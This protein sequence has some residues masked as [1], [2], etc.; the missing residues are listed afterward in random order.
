MMENTRKTEIFENASI[1]KAVLTLC[2]PTVIS[3]L[4]M[5][6][7][8]LADTWFVGL[9]ND[10][11]QN[12]AVTFAAP[13]LLAFNA[14]NNLFGVGTSSMMGRALG[15]KDINTV[16]R[17]SAFGFWAA[18]VCGILFSIIVFIFNDGL[19]ALLGAQGDN[20]ESTRGY[21]YWT[22][23]WGAAPSILNV[24]LAYLVRTEGAVM[25]ASIGTMGGCLLNII[26][27]PIFVLPQ[28]LDMGAAGAGLATFISNV[29]A[30]LYFFVL[31]FI[32]RK[33]TFVCLN[34]VMAR[35][36]KNIVTGIFSVGIPAAI[37]NLLN[38]TGMTVLNNFTADFG[39][40]AVAAMG[41]AYKIYMI[42][43]QAAWGISQG[44]MPFISYNY[45]SKRIERAK[46]IVRFTAKIAVTFLAA[47]TVL[48]IIFSGNLISLFIKNTTIIDYGTH[49]LRGMSLALVFHFVDFLGVGVFQS[50]GNGL[51]SLIFAIL[52]KIILEIP[53]LI[54]LNK[55]FPL[56][57]LPYAQFAAEFVLAGASVITLVWLFNKTALQFTSQAHN[58]N[59]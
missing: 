15:R 56:Y 58:N 43:M 1:P 46:D 23:C 34:P 5:V 21:L 16:K 17:S 2:V 33:T 45:G 52:R 57:G 40:H 35:P 51:L 37:Q 50:F 6:L 47:V 31:L 26:L 25:H 42:P 10:P 55:L 12:A 18:A 7:Y 30:C 3:S 19:L 8:N 59:L 36:K 20:I 54:I 4:V 29:C 53:A 14:V 48:F 44:I 39:S 13:V 32:R 24:V 28:C 9:L 27:D 38:V 41:I 11:V 49:F 22:V